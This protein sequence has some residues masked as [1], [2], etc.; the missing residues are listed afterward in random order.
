MMHIEHDT[1]DIL[2]GQMSPEQLLA[3]ITEQVSKA[4]FREKSRHI[5]ARDV[6]FAAFHRH[7]REL[8][9]DFSQDEVE[10][11]H[12]FMKEQV[13]VP[14]R[15]GTF[16]RPLFRL[17]TEF[18]GNTL[19]VEGD[20]PICRS[21]R[22]LEWRDISFRLGQDLFTCAHLAQ[23]D[24]SFSVKRDYF[25]WPSILRSN[26]LFVARLMEQKTADNHYHLVGSTRLFSLSWI[27]LMNHPRHI[28]SFLKDKKVQAQFKENLSPGL[29]YSSRDYQMS[30]TDRLR[31]AAWLRVVLFRRIVGL[32]NTV[33]PRDVRSFVEDKARQ[34]T[35]VVRL[36]ETSR[37]L[38]GNKV[39][40]FN[41]REM[42]IDY[43]FCNQL[44]GD[45]RN[46][47]YNRLLSGERW[48]LYEC[49]RRCFSGA[50]ST[51]E[52]DLFYLY[53]LLCSHVRRELI[54]VNGAVGFQNFANYQNRKDT[55]WGTYS[56][57]R[58][59]S[60]RL[61]L[62]G[63]LEEGRI[64]SLEARLLPRSI[65]RGNSKLLFDIDKLSL[66]AKETRSRK[67][68]KQKIGLSRSEV[69]S[70]GENAKY[71]YVLH[72]SKQK[73][74]KEK[75]IVGRVLPRNHE[76][77]KRAKKQAIALASDLRRDSYLCAL[78]RGIDACSAEI[79]SRPEIFATEFRFLRGFVPFAV[80][81]KPW[82][83]SERVFPLLGV[84]YHAGEDFLD[85]ADGLRA[86]DEAILFLGMR[87]KDRLGHALALGIE[88]EEHYER[89]NAQV[90]LPKQD[91]LDNLVWLLYRSI[92]LGV[93]IPVNLRQEMERVSH[94]LFDEIYRPSIGTEIG[95]ISLQD[96][97]NAWRQRGD[98]PDLYQNL[99]HGK[100]GK[101]V[102]GRYAAC[103]NLSLYSQYEK[104]KESNPQAAAPNE[105]CCVLLYHYHFD[106]Q[107]REL[108]AKQSAFQVTNDYVGLIRLMQ[109]A[110]MKQLCNAG[111][112]VECN[113]SSNVLIGT[114]RDYEHHPIFRFNS[115]GLEDVRNPYNLNVSINTDDQ[116]VFDT[117]LENEYALLWACLER[118]R[119][120]EGDRKYSND[121]IYHYL[122]HL[123]ELGN[124]Q[125]FQ[126]A[127]RRGV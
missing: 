76:C 79:G 111:I 48:L 49:F 112:E 70:Y 14:H 53:I 126:K 13:S 31:L 81:R 117:S 20:E 86:I 62:E 115:F 46:H 98:H 55:L 77:R 127:S 54:Q 64:D 107:V 7:S 47:G 71:F 52:Q 82:E 75:A 25:A 44:N 61:A 91:H 90:I 113:P 106:A 114:F 32:E 33:S 16:S 57:Y 38:Y 30:W 102:Q 3:E 74:R 101:R 37:L 125:V 99:S 9:R 100:K 123:R 109:D 124:V 121:E 42:C 97:Y 59:E 12:R 92:E 73:N 34:N 66:Y 68:L 84:T 50:F 43:A 87:R 26:N 88:P 78:V 17:L 80:Q 118:Q 10:G 40:Q 58:A 24:L 103:G 63:T 122:N 93:V 104:F 116:G 11:I 4:G 5:S 119:T 110:L 83:S 22:I 8:F 6:E 35:C 89:K 51:L 60:Y 36:V 56:E 19:L 94:E 69:F 67:K 95:S 39:P 85:I 28:V 72:F 18:T 23:N 65:R 29:L 21:E 41:G 2:F 120:P 15:S 105:R 108:G 27:C 1:L 45:D 96:Y